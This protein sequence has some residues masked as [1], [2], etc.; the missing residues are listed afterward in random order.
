MGLVLA[1]RHLLAAVLALSWAS[2]LWAQPSSG[3]AGIYTCVDSRGR[4]LTSDRP[5]ADCADRDQKELSSSGTV[6]RIVKPA[7]TAD[8]QRVADEKAQIENEE[9]IRL[10]EEKRKDRAL[11]ARYPNRAAHDQERNLALNQVDEVIKAASKRIG[12]LAVQR[13][14]IDAELEFYK[15]DPKKTPQSLKRQIEDND[16]SVAVQKRFIADQDAEKKRVNVRFDEELARLKTVW[17]LAG[18]VGSPNPSTD[19]NKR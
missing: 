14:S 19:K 15:K 8:E 10:Q 9:R 3:A 7:M 16:S 11:L 13:K 18:V 6:K 5:I 12:E 1:A 17:T 2:S 4:K